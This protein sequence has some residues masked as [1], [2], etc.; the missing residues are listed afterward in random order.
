VQFVGGL[1]FQLEKAMNALGPTTREINNVGTHQQ[2]SVKPNC[3]WFKQF[4]E[5]NYDLTRLTT[6]GPA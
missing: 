4:A 5:N 1:S 6:S 3:S 2:G